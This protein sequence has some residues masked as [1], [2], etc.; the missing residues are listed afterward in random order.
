MIKHTCTLGHFELATGLISGVQ[1]W[2]SFTVYFVVTHQPSK[3]PPPNLKAP[4]P[5]QEPSAVPKLLGR[6]FMKCE[7]VFYWSSL[8]HYLHGKGQ[9]G[10]EGLEKIVPTLSEFCG[11]IQRLETLFTAI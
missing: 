7:E 5:S 9:E 10:E 11:Y 6:D 4:T 2:G 1:I 3:T 8:C